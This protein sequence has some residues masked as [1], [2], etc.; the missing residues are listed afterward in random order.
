MKTSTSSAHFI[1]VTLIPLHNVSV[2]TIQILFCMPYDGSI[3][4]V[5]VVTTFNF[6]AIYR[7][8]CSIVLCIL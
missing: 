5:I 4:I 2:I 3:V 7:C 8:P 1:T 6:V